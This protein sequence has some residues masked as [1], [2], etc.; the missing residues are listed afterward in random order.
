VEGFAFCPS[1]FVWRFRYHQHCERMH[2]MQ[3]TKQLIL[4]LLALGYCLSAAEP[5][6]SIRQSVLS[7]QKEWTNAVLKGDGRTL[8]KLLTADLS[9]THSSAKTQTKQE[10]IHDAAGGGTTYKSIEF[11]D[12]KLR[13]YG[14]T[15]VITHTAKIDTVQTGASQLYI[16]EVWVHQDGRWQM[17]SRQATKLP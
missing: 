10:F 15:V 2:S 8:E 7:A 16:T 14:D 9:Y 6:A 13:Q 4:C 11:A 17:A 5:S 1:F 12:A 3:R